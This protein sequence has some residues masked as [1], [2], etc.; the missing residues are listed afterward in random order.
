MPGR[1]ESDLLQVSSEAVSADRWPVAPDQ[2]LFRSQS[3]VL[4]SL[5]GQVAFSPDVFQSCIWVGPPD[6]ASKV[7]IP[8]PVF[9]HS[10]AFVRVSQRLWEITAEQCRKLWRTLRN[11]QT[12][13][14]AR[15]E[16]GLCRA[17]PRLS[18]GLR[19]STARFWP[20]LR[21][22]LARIQPGLSQGSAT[23]QSG[24]I[25]GLTRAERGLR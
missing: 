18:H 1:S 23:L 19:Q 20:G 6:Q 7:S 22:G 16:S 17:E 13:R 9:C 25:Q 3:V 11:G 24:F 2:P 21:Q 5:G 8:A 4:K 14:L 15:A 10:D 12:L